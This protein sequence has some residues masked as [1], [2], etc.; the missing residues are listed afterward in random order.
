MYC[1]ECRFFHEF[2]DFAAEVNLYKDILLRDILPQ[3]LH[4]DDNSGGLL[5]SKNGFAYPPFMVLLL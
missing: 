3:L 4:A 1:V 5:R 2:D